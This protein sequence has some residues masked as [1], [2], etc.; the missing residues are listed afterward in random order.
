ME[1]AVVSFSAAE[2]EDIGGHFSALVSRIPLGRITSPTDYDRAV[3]V[4]NGLMDVGAGDERHPLAGLLDLIGDFIADYDDEHH[5]LPEGTPVDALRFLMQQHGLRQGDL[6]EVGSQGVV[7]EVLS[8]KRDLNVDQ[9]R[10]LSRRFGVA[11]A[12]F[13]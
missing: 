13:L 7:S 5:R 12:T 6:P 10:R 1:Q 2:V 8:G 9:I 3:S 4:L 11:P